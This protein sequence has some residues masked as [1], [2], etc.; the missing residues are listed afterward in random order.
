[1]KKRYIDLQ[2]KRFSPKAVSI[3]P[4][5]INPPGDFTVPTNIPIEEMR[6]NA[7]RAV[8]LLKSMANESRLLILCHLSQD[9]LTVG[10]LVNLV[11]LSQ[12]AL[13]QH[14]SVLRREGLVTTRRSSQFIY[15]SLASDDVKAVIRTLYERFCVP[16]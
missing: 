10:E 6:Q 5:L 11:E 1:M 12:S 13:S 7:T 8:A 3:T 9:E 14:L 4:L 16:A 15:Y 2:E